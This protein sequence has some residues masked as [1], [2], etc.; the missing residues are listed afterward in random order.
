LFELISFFG[1]LVSLLLVA[2]HRRNTTD[3]IFLALYFASNTFYALTIQ[4]FFTAE[5][6]WIVNLT[7]PYFILLNQNSGV[8]LWL[9]LKKKFYPN[10][11]L[12]KWDFLHFL[13]S[14]FIFVNSSPYI[15]LNLVEK[16]YYLDLFFK[17]H[18]ANI[19]FPTLFIEYK[20][21]T[22]Y[23][24]IATVGYSVFGIIN[25][26]ILFRTKKLPQLLSFEIKYI[27][28]LLLVSLIY[29]LSSLYV[30][31]QIGDSIV[32]K[33]LM[34]TNYADLFIYARL[35]Y[36]GL[37]VFN[38][39]FPQIIFQSLNSTKEPKVKKSNLELD[40][41][42]LPNYDL[43]AIERQLEEYLQTKPFLKP[44]FSLYQFAEE[45]KLPSHQL[46]YYLK[47]R[48]NQNF[49]DFKNQLR[50]EYAIEQLDLGM[51]KSHTL[52]T[53]S[54]NCGFR[55]RTNFVDAFK[56]VTG[57]TPSDYLKK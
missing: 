7:F 47:V 32:R 34:E 40:E 41:K 3:N 43:D 30:M 17:S 6:R 21:Q 36:F 46:S 39:F 12:S 18:G 23:R 52:E 29:Y 53:I 57:K 26:L 49:N 44:G 50:I 11:K 48:F 15:F 14:I 31:Y 27:V 2:F 56:K 54:Q 4:S 20:Y 33:V 51:A 55:S 35:S 24:M 16:T 9:Y 10:L 1:L 42:V 38:F 25:F 8:F 28:G 22:G 19:S 13:P 5:L 37:I 45:T